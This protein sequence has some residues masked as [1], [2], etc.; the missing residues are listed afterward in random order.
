MKRV[1]LTS[2]G[3]LTLLLCLL[4]AC[5]DCP[6]CPGQSKQVVLVPQHEYDSLG[7]EA[8]EAAVWL[9]GEV[10]APT[11][12][13]ERM[14][15]D[16]WLIRHQF[17]DSISATQVKFVTPW[18]ASVVYCTVTDGVYLRI[19]SGVYHG[20][21]SLNAIYHLDTV[22]GGYHWS[23]G[24]EIALRFEGVQHSVRLAE[25]YRTLPDF[26]RA[27]AYTGPGDRASLIP[28]WVN[29]TLTYIFREAWGDC[30]AGCISANLEVF[31]VRDY[32]PVRELSVPHGT[33]IPPEWEA[34]LREALLCHLSGP[35][36][37]R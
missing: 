20:W 10:T 28:W 31:S 35:R 4:S 14:Q 25:I 21:D 37:E 26:Q 22:T 2:V 8:E 7:R 30:E 19:M 12:L 13:K 29:G 17:G 23:G 5:S 15:L 3:G 11:D 34:V 27:Y 24:V 33:E 18:H 6:N 9:S 36:C 32:V 16:L 1:A